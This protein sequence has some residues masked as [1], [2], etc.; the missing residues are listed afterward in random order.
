MIKDYPN[1]SLKLVAAA[2]LMIASISAVVFLYKDSQKRSLL[3]SHAY[4]S[5]KF[6]PNETS[7]NVY[8]TI[9]KANNQRINSDN[10]YPSFKGSNSSTEYTPTETVVPTIT[11]TSIGT[12]MQNSTNYSN[13]QTA[14]N[15]N[16]N[17]GISPITSSINSINPSSQNSSGNSATS[18]LSSSSIFAENSSIGGG[19][20]LSNNGRM[21]V[22]GDPGEPGVVPVGNGNLI[23]ILLISMYGFL[24]FR[25]S[26]T[27]K[28]GTK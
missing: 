21:L 28:K 3:Y 16:N 5:N 13:Q 27:I 2:I 11:S 6:N 17:I 14:T 18:N 23:L 19:N 26:N 24:K 25:A 9:G 7:A 15:T 20:A 10:N 22:D 8:P 1:L 12:G 4:S